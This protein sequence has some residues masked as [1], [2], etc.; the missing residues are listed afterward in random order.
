[1]SQPPSAPGNLPAAVRTVGREHALPTVLV[2]AQYYL[3]SEKAG[4]GLRTIVNM[5]ER[6][7][8]RFHF[9]VV[10]T[11]RDIGDRAPYS[12][13]KLDQWNAIGPAEVFYGTR[14][15]LTLCGLRRLTGHLRADAVYLN[16]FFSPLTAK[17]LFLARM[18]L[19]ENVP[20]IVAPEGELAPTAL[21]LKRLRK[22]AYRVATGMLGLYRNVLWKAAAP[23]EATD[24]RA[25]V[26][27]ARRIRIAPNMPPVARELPNPV[28][29]KPEKQPGE[30]HLVFLSRIAPIK[31]LDWALQ[32]LQTVEGR[33]VL[34]IYGP[35]EDKSYWVSCMESIRHLPANI[36][37]HYRGAVAA[38]EVP[39]VLTRYHFMILPTLG[40]NFGHVVIESLA[41]GCPVIISNRTPWVDLAQKNLGWDLPLED[42]QPW[43]EALSACVAM[44]ADKYREATRSA[45]MYA[46]AWLS[47][48]EVEQDTADVLFEATRLADH[49]KNDSGYEH[50]EVGKK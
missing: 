16:S 9:R 6:L 49:G 25:C 29:A 48:A 30:L 12:S 45:Q 19:V 8:D 47:S 31:N 15:S 36:S 50:S 7:S 38:S 28:C 27:G 21:K 23:H 26:T 44:D 34:D 22:K 13:V 18:R 37:A 46:A 3:P 5:I 33:V 17:Y 42:I 4:G 20:T 24:I 1:M 2:L 35:L 43:R 10:T 14:A 40:E 32:A 39:D 11:D 41:A